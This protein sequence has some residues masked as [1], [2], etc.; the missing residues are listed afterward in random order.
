MLSRT[1]LLQPW[2]HTSDA[3]PLRRWKSSVS[4]CLTTPPPLWLCLLL[5]L[6]PAHNLPS[7]GSDISP[8]STTFCLQPDLSAAPSCSKHTSWF[9]LKGQLQQI[10]TCSLPLTPKSRES[11]GNTSR[12]RGRLPL[13]PPPA[14]HSFTTTP[15]PEQRLQ[16]RKDRRLQA[17][18]SHCL[19]RKEKLELQGSAHI[20]CSSHPAEAIRSA[21]PRGVRRK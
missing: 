12:P 7:Q 1:L 16:P 15:M 2:S 6:S 11:D 9:G 8:F 14:S 19:P 20:I 4:E 21:S 10:C 5:H 3:R 13:L 17:G 18:C